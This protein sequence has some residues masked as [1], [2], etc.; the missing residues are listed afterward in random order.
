MWNGVVDGAKGTIEALNF[1]KTIS[2][3]IELSED[4]AI[5]IKDL[6]SQQRKDYEEII[7]AIDLQMK[8]A[9]DD[10][11]A[12]FVGYVVGN[13]IFEIALSKG[14][15]AAVQ[16]L[17]TL[18]KS[19]TFL[20]ALNK[21]KLGQMTVKQV[22]AIGEAIDGIRSA[23]RSSTEA[24][25]SKVTKVFSRIN[26][27]VD[28]EYAGVGRVQID[29]FSLIDDADTICQQRWKNYCEATWADTAGDLIDDA[30]EALINGQHYTR[31][32]RI[33]TLKPDVTYVSNGYKYQ[34]DSLGRITNAKGKLQLCEAPRNDYAQRVVGR[35]DRYLLFS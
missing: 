35:I 27:I 25:K 10:D 3:M 22:K 2:N 9:K 34:T 17:K 26:N 1:P 11:F 21:T 32:G 19:E 30:E 31:N 12:K 16:K 8:L 6:N 28:L 23:I 24:L 13:Y 18:V 15:A 29:D 20:N 7:R 14:V 5:A 4:I 33:K